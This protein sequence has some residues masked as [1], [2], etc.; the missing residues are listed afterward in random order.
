MNRIMIGIISLLLPLAGLCISCAGAFYTHKAWKTKQMIENIPRSKV[1]SVAI[2][3]A[4][5][6]GKAEAD[7]SKKIKSPFSGKECLYCSYRVE[8][9]AQVDETTK[10]ETYRVLHKGSEH[11]PFYLKDSTGRILVD[12][13]GSEFFGDDKTEIRS[14]ISSKPSPRIISFLESKGISH[15]GIFLNKTMR[16][17]ESMIIPG[18]TL[19]VLGSAMNNPG[20]KGNAKDNSENIMLKKGDNDPFFFI[21]NFKEE[22]ILKRYNNQ[23]IIGGIASGIIGLVSIKYILIFLMTFF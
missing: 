20:F 4:E 11:V 16:F 9:L 3:L 17:A 1:R 13:E 21:G 14:A 15:K 10:Q 19:Y 8:Q 2:G 23:M 7:G 18:D 22:E 6:E 12:P 5:L